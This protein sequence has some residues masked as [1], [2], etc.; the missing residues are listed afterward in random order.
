M[1]INLATIFLLLV[2][3]IHP[4]CYS[5]NQK[6]DSL[7]I[8]L[9]KAKED[10]SKVKILVALCSEYRIIGEMDKA[11]QLGNEG[12]KLTRELNWKKGEAEILTN[13]GIVHWS[14]GNYSQALT[15]YSKALRINEQIGDEAKIANLFVYS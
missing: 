6:M 9:K 5:Q 8:A 14:Q 10:T 12:L 2:V 4:L 3:F 1:K 13:I 7:S 15:N 11:I